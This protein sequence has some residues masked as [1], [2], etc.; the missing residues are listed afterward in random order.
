MGTCRRF[1]YPPVNAA[2]ARFEKALKIDRALQKKIKK[3][4]QRIEY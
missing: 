3:V 4:A 2:I 1:E